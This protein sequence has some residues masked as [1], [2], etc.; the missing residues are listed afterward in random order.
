MESNWAAEHLQVIR[1]LMERSAL[2]RRTLA[3]IMLYLGVLG[4]A[5]A[6]A[7]IKL[8]YRTMPRF[9]ELWLGTALVAAAG[10]LLIVR[11]QALRARE[12][13]W[14]PPTRC[15]AQAVLPALMGGMLAGLILT[16]LG[17]GNEFRLV[18]VWLL[19]YGCALHAAGFYML[20][21]MRLF[22]WFYIFGACLLLIV[23]Y[24]FPT[25]TDRGMHWFMGFFFGILQ[26][27][28]GVYL[29]F[30]EKGNNAV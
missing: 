25:S 23:F 3:P 30:T 17:G 8:Q 22:G 29:L 2:Y 27:A 9:G 20:R 15:V 19:L 24:V 5:T 10:A 13:F 14:S 16:F 6:A 11:R 4:I 21:G 26:L 1:T 18:C 12:P 28:Y 7:G